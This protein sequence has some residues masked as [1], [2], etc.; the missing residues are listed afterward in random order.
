MK[1][2]SAAMTIAAFAAALALAGCL[3]AE[4]CRRD[5][6]AYGDPRS[7]ARD[8]RSIAGQR[9]VI[10]SQCRR[11]SPFPIQRIQY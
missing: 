7:P 3:D 6:A 11:H 4:A 9:R 2:Y 5:A 1:T 8:V 10:T